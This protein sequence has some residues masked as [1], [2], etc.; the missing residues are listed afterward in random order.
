MRALC[1]CVRVRAI[2]SIARR[3]TH[4]GTKR[5][6]MNAP[7]AAYLASRCARART[8]TH[9]NM[10]LR[11]APIQRSAEVEPRDSGAISTN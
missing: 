5:D 2:I 9:V 7:T 4:T 1:V 3:H 8:H 11:R 6:R 10:C